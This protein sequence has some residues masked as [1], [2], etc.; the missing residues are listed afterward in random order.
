M[1]FNIKYLVGFNAAPALRLPYRTS[2]AASKPPVANENPLLRMIRN[3]DFSR[4]I[5][6]TCGIFLQ[7]KR[8]FLLR[9]SENLRLPCR[10]LRRSEHGETERCWSGNPA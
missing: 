2:F 5:P 10:K 1:L 7:E 6:Q 3:L 4:K 9:K 8:V